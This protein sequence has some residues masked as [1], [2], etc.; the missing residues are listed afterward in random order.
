MP[1]FSRAPTWILQ[2]KTCFAPCA[3]SLY[4]PSPPPPPNL[5]VKINVA[6]A[7]KKPE[8]TIK[9]RTGATEIVP[10][11]HR[12]FDHVKVAASR[13]DQ[14]QQQQSLCSSGAPP[15]SG[16]ATGGSARGGG[17]EGGSGASVCAEAN[18]RVHLDAERQILLTMLLAQMCS[19][20]DATP[21]TFVEQVGVFCT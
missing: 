17:G 19:E 11:F 21:R 5:Y 3:F 2:Y 13:K 16:T 12:V 1:R 10:F 20:H 8:S 15:S 14:Q 7:K 18:D 4:I 6:R 9:H